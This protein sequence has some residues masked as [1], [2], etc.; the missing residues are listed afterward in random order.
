MK[1][2]IAL[3]YNDPLELPILARA[4]EEHG[5][6]AVILS[7]HLVYPATLRTPYPYTLD[8]DRRLEELGVTHLIT[9]PWLLYGKGATVEEK[10]AG[11]ERFAGDAIEPM[12]GGE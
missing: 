4:A 3:A 9:V 2:C 5:F 1:F 6:A 12:R 10:V 8:T 7:D 11:I